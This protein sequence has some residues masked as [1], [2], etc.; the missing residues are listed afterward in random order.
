MLARAEA[1]ANDLIP[2]DGSMTQEYIQ[3]DT[4]QLKDNDVE[5]DV[6]VTTTHTHKTHATY[7][8]NTKQEKESNQ[9]ERAQQIRLRP[10]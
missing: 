9:R 10:K 6:H 7:N 3:G 4:T 5:H 2:S 8:A 1:H